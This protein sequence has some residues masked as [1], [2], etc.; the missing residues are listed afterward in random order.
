MEVSRS[1]CGDCEERRLGAHLLLT[2]ASKDLAAT[3]ADALEGNMA[4]DCASRIEKGSVDVAERF[5]GDCD[6]T[7]EF[8]K[9]DPVSV[10]L[11]E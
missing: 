2:G 10:L 6:E 7:R 9:R 1:F 5:C 3:I 4:D 8:E 11:G